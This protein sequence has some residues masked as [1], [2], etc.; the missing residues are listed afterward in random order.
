M[1]GQGGGGTQGIILFHLENNEGSMHLSG[2]A[3][4]TA[5]LGFH[6]L[7]LALSVPLHVGHVNRFAHTEG[8]HTAEKWTANESCSEPV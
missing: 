7:S 6:L 1:R 5:P 2:V 4:L 3:V 8:K